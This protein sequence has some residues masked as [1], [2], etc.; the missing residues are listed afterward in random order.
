MRRCDAHISQ[1]AKDV[2][3]IQETLIDAFQRIEMFFRRLEVYIEVPATKEMMEIIVQILV[4]VLSI[5]GIATKKIK[6][7]RMSKCLP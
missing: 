5:L 6:E 3:T 1:A 4:E 7:S 2:Q